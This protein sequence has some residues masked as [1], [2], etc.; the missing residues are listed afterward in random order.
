MSYE[1]TPDQELC[2]IIGKAKVIVETLN[3]HDGYIEVGNHIVP[4][5][6]ILHIETLS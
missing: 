3:I 1:V 6:H 5:S 4:L 2:N